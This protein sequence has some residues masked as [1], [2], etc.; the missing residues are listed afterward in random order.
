MIA[1]SIGN[2]LFITLQLASFLDHV[3]ETVDPVQTKA[4]CFIHQAFKDEPI[5]RA[6]EGLLKQLTDAIEFS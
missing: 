1:G 6:G 3:V 5:R 4:V 2:G